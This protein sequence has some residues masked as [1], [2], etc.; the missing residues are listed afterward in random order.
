MPGGSKAILIDDPTIFIGDDRYVPAATRKD[1]C[2]FIEKALKSDPHKRW[3]NA[4][5]MSEEL[6]ELL[7]RRDVKGN[8]SL[9]LPWGSQPSLVYDEKGDMTMGWIMH[10]HLLT[11]PW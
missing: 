3:P 9:T 2:R 1:W 4:R 10:S 11:R 6:R 8:V 5:I 7:D